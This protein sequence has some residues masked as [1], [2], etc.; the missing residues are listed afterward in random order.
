VDAGPGDGEQGGGLDGH[1]F[2][3]DSDCAACQ[4][5]QLEHD[6]NAHPA[7]HAYPLG[8]QIVEHSDELIVGPGR[9]RGWRPV[10]IAVRGKAPD[11]AVEEVSDDLP[12][13]P[14]RSGLPLPLGLAQ[15]SQERHQ[16]RVQ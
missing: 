3:E 15:L 5:E 10:G 2:Q 14:F 8:I 7:G 12:H 13:S 6:P 9:G 11:I 16:L 4:I 1:T